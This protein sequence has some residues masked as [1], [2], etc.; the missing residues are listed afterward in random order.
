MIHVHAEA[1][2][3]INSAVEKTHKKALHF[4]KTVLK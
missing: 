2:R 3:N 1:A 4:L